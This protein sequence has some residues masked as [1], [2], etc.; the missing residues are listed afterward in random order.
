MILYT[1]LVGRF[2]MR[3][4]SSPDWFLWLPVEF[5]NH[6]TSVINAPTEVAGAQEEKKTGK[7]GDMA[8]EQEAVVAILAWT[9]DWAVS[10]PL[11]TFFLQIEN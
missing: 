1:V 11:F 3:F 10:V 4:Y 5:G 6:C 8:K 7:L 2:F 9:W